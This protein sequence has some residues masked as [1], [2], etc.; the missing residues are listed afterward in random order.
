MYG[1]NSNGFGQEQFVW[2]IRTEPGVLA[3]FEQLWQQTNL[4]VSFD[5]GS[6][7]LPGIRKFTRASVYEHF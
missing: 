5:G 2:D 7:M 4:V 6:L 3:A 1:G